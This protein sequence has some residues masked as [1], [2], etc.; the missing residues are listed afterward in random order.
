M[1]QSYACSAYDAADNRTM[2]QDGTGTTYWS[3]DALNRIT[4]EEGNG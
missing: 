4:N 2:M 1:K 3:Y